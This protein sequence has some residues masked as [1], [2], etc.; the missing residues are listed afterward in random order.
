MSAQ[1][2]EIRDAVREAGSELVLMAVPTKCEY[3]ADCRGEESAPRPRDGAHRT[4]EETAGR[5]GIR[6]VP[7]LDVLG[8]EH[9]W[10][11]DGHWRPE[12]HARIA[13]RLGER[14]EAE[15]LLD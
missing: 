5:L 14:L 9:F 10:E 7:T 4:L 12:G 2:D 8:P 13:E 11:R 15:A 6:F 3:S 1:A